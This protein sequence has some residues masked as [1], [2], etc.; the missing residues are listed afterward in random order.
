LG[1][2]NTP[3]HPNPLPKERGMLFKKAQTVAARH[4]ELVSGSLGLL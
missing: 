1:H 4:P 2:D 3:P